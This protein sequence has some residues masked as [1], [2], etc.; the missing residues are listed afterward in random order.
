MRLTHPE[1]SQRP[2]CD[3]VL[4]SSLFG[5]SKSLSFINLVSHSIQRNDVVADKTTDNEILHID[6]TSPT[7]TLQQ[8]S[9]ASTGRYWCRESHAS[10]NQN[11]SSEFHHVHEKSKV[12]FA[13]TSKICKTCDCEEMFREKEQEIIKLKEEK[14]EQSKQLLHK[15][16]ENANLKAKNAELNLLLDHL[17][18]KLLAMEM[19]L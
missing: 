3:E 8:D 19:K 14:L 5:A 15:E 6:L 11:C 16:L 10:F 4:G 18:I 2:S 7:Q 13:N 12:E 9:T 1:P 17:K